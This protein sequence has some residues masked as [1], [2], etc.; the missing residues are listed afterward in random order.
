MRSTEKARMA[1]VQGAGGGGQGLAHQVGNRPRQGFRTL[2]WFQWGDIG[3]FK[4]EN[5]HDL[6]YGF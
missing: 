2:L 1:G 5:K 4:A 6:I 3:V